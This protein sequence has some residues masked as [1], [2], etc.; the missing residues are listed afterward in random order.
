MP[1]F[2]KVNPKVFASLFT[3]NS[4]DYER[5]RDAL[6]KLVLN[7]SSLIYEPEVS[8]AL[9]FG[10]RCGF[11]GTLHMEVVR[12]RLE[13]EYNLDL[14]STAPSVEYQVLKTNGDLIK[15]DSP[16]QLPEPPDIDE[17][18]EPIVNTTILTP[19]DYV[20][21]VISICTAKRLSLIHI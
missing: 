21:N 2:E 20:G 13:R 14:I 4:D 19:N 7:D 16:S 8:D 12:E 9:G 18:R 6:S 3:V 5:F 10:F 17:I 15:I 11:L 1:G